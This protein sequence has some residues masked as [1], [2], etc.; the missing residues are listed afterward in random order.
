MRP[1]MSILRRDKWS[2]DPFGTLREKWGTVPLAAGDRVDGATLLEVP[3]DELMSL[4]HAGYTTE[5][6][7]DRRGWYR[8]LYR[9]LMTGKK[10]LDVGCG[11]AYDSL[12]FADIAASVTL[13]DIV[14]SNLEI[15]RRVASLKDLDN[16]DYLYIDEVAAF[17]G[18]AD[19]YDVVMAIGSL[20]HAPQKVVA[21][22]IDALSR[23][24]KLGGRWLQFAYPK[25]RWERDG[26]LPFDVWGPVTDGP[27]TPWTEW[28]DVDKLMALLPER[29]APVFYTEWHGGEFNWFDLVATD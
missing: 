14:G 11:L 6:E 26:S 17:D 5:G 3:D 12:G 9:D 20:H 22:E 1:A 13:A 10:I 28:Y 23:R 16:V 15:C 8:L 25:V 7:L 29:F 2:R 27:G 24:L 21:P 18:L 4:W 19:D